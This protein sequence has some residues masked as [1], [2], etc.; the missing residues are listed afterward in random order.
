M[1]RTIRLT[2]RKQLPISCVGV[3]IKNVGNKRLVTLAV[4]DTAAFRGFPPDAR[5]TLRLFENQQVELLDFGLLSSPKVAVDLQNIAFENPSC[6]LRVASS[7]ADRLGLLLGST[8]TWRLISER[9]PGGGGAKGILYFKPGKIAPR[10]WKLDLQEGAHPIVL[11]DERIP[12]ARAWVK[13]DPVFVAAVLPAILQLI[14]N[15]I[16]SQPSPEDTEWMNDWICWADA[17][18]PG[19]PRPADGD[20][21]RVRADW[22][23]RLVETFCQRHK[24]SDRIVDGLA[25]ERAA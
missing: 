14:F 19:Y 5:L 11:V 20:D 17:L 18:M 25:R 3:S 9:K 7:D 6:Q 15:D 21:A 10:A 16:L 2:G 22:I 24:L 4:S 1:R 23:E 12:D 8:R 13:T